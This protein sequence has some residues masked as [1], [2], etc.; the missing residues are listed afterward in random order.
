MA[1]RTVIFF[2]GLPPQLA[3]RSSQKTQKISY[4]DRLVRD[5]SCIL[6]SG[7]RLTSST[8]EPTAKVDSRFCQSKDVAMAI[9]SVREKLM[10]GDVSPD[11][12]RKLGRE[13]NYLKDL[14]KTL[15]Q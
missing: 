3:V 4:K 11:S 5:V 15:S 1:P 7:K 13:M 12:A 10:G 2:V 8:E 9:S 14:A 6:D